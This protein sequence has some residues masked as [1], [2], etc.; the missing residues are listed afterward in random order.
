MLC[1]RGLCAILLGHYRVKKHI[2]LL[3]QNTK[4]T[5]KNTKGKTN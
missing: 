1:N 3:K 2:H 4:T 5:L